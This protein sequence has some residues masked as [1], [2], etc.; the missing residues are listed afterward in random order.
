MDSKQ[1][2]RI[3]VFAILVVLMIA[4][5]EIVA[6]LYFDTQ[7]H[8]VTSSV[9]TALSLTDKQHSMYVN[10]NIRCHLVLKNDTTATNVSRAAGVQGQ[11]AAYSCT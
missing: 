10:D 3:N 8:A 4:V 9:D 5:P 11:Y 1:K 6:H 2:K 7:K